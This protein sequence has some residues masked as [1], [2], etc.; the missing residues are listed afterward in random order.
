[1]AKSR[2]K[3]ASHTP[4]PVAAGNLQLPGQVVLVM[5]G[6][7]ALGAF[8]AG[9][10]EAMHEAGIEPDWVVGTSIGAINGAIIAGNSSQNRLS[11]LRQFWEMVASGAA[12]APHW[13]AFGMGNLMHNLN[14]VAR[15]IPGFFAPNPASWVGAHTPLGISDASY[16]STAP[17]RRTL[18]ELVDFGRITK[19]G[20]RLTLG[21]VNVNL[22]RMRY[23]DSRDEVV[24]ID[25]VMASGALPPAFPAA[26]ID[27]EP[28]WDGGIYSNT[29][30]EVVMDDHP[31]RDSVIFAAQLWQQEDAEPQTI[32]HVMARLKDIQY[33]SR[34]A[35]HIA[36]QQQIHH[37]R[38]VVRELGRLMPASA[39][40][41]PE[42]KELLGWGCGTVM[43]VL[44]LQAPLLDGDDHTKDID[45]TPGGIRARWA[46]GRELTRRR[47]AEAPW[48]GAA[49]PRAGIL[50][51]D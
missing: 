2:T 27:G 17:L 10:Y 50:V 24:G 18:A 48:R 35:S 29:P 20:T 16:Y 31:R 34:A 38:H 4:S 42:I 44:P 1:M 25:H 30:I 46:A 37:L 36:R 13:K 14:T 51:H 9:V 28:F 12:S 49:D 19:G 23:F 6:G 11:R 5:Q 39:R 7:G 45:F 32:Q 21:A 26:V 22:G 40:A 33:S 3:S 15:G 41:K 43:H 47:L 8:Q